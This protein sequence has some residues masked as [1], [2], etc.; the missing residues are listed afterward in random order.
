MSCVIEYFCEKMQMVLSGQLGDC[1][2]GVFLS[3]EVV[4]LLN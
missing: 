1:S 3:G 2:V 4:R